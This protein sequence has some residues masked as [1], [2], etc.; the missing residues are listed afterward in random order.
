MFAIIITFLGLASSSPAPDTTF[1]TDVN[2][3]VYA[4]DAGQ[5][6]FWQRSLR[7]GQVPIKNPGVVA[8]FRHAKTDNY[9]D[10][11]GWKYEVEATAWGGKSNDVL[12]TQAYVAGRFKKWELWAGRRKEIIGLGDTSLTSGFYAWSGNATPMPKVQFGT[13]DYI[14]IFKGW[15]GLHMTYSHGWFDNQ[16]N[17]L[18]AYLHQKTLYGRI[19]KPN[20]FINVFGGINHNVSW[21]GES[22]VKTGGE[23]DYYPSDLT[24]Y[25]Y[26]VTALKDRS[27]VKINQT[28][29]Y[30]DANNQFGNH[31]GSIDL[32]LKLQPKWGQ[33]LVYKQ[34]PYETGRVA[35]LTTFD[36]GI[37][38][39]SFRL[40]E[41]SF[42]DHIVLE[43]IY[44]ANQGTY[45]SWLGK[46][47]NIP[48]PH[49]SE[50]ESY[51]NNGG[52]GSFNY[53]GKG[54]GT[55]MIIIDSESL[56][57]GDRT[58]TYNAVNSWYL[59]IGGQVSNSLLYQFR[60]SYGTHAKILGP[61]LKQLSSSIDVQKTLTNKLI[62][63][64]SL[65]IDQG[66]RL[67]GN[68][69]VRIGAKY[70]IQ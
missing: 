54:I 26:V 41:K 60:L 52:R 6:P 7:Y 50:I 20:S 44:T 28:L 31:L 23:Y 59:G 53:Q 27:I 56:Q 30:D 3:A 39:I 35:S 51:F 21:G 11:L 64:G 47:L 25:F 17:T 62:L 5:T 48:D 10:K 15:V 63:Q 55:P 68:V 58:F 43:N 40:K 18:N 19:G 42:V 61:G 32:A 1:R 8:I 65:A 16:G 66:D 14:N 24:A 67:P 4:S 29:S 22:R 2:L 57:G 45:I 33:V 9:L 12:L 36:D 37:T 49:K 34:T 13:R 46:L 38:G 70:I 69:G